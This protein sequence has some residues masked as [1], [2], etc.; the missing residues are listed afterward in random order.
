[1][2]VWS[3]KPLSLRVLKCTRMRFGKIFI[4][5][6]VDGEARA[7]KRERGAAIVS[8][9]VHRACAGA[10]GLAYFSFIQHDRVA[11]PSIFKQ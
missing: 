10:P 6:A 11:V 2:C 3:L 7:T 5:P 4:S 8:Y 1:M 9:K